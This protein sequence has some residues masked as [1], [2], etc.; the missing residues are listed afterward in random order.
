M[1]IAILE[2]YKVMLSILAVIVIGGV[3]LAGT[4]ESGKPAPDNPELAQE[5]SAE[6][7]PDDAQSEEEDTTIWGAASF[8]D[9]L[10]DEVLDDEDNGFASNAPSELGDEA[11]DGGFEPR[12]SEKS[13]P[14]FASASQASKPASNTPA[15]RVVADATRGISAPIAVDASLV[16]PEVGGKGKGGTNETD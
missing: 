4:F 16:S 11:D 10:G 9:M 13:E 7:K 5:Q 6:D 1:S 14:T 2:K 12:S 15:K 3:I 8:D